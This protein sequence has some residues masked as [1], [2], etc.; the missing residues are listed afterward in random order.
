[1]DTVKYILGHPDFVQ[2]IGNIYPV[3]VKDYDKFNECSNVL[4]ITSQH[5]EFNVGD[6]YKLL[7][8]LV[9][10]ENG[11]FVSQLEQLFSLVTREKVVFVCSESNYGFVINEKYM[12]NRDNYEE[13]R[14]IVMKQNLLFEQ[15]VYKDKLVQEWA[16]RAM[17]AK[18]K[19]GIKITIQ[20]MITTISV[21]TGKNYE[22][23]SDMTI[24]QLQADF[25]RIN[26]F[27]DYQ[28]SVDFKCA[29][30]EKVNINHFAGF[31]NLF[32]SPYDN[33]FVSSNKLNNIE[34]AFK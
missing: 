31:I 1:M 30:A 3:K 25:K 5:F 8:L 28:T 27:Q 15:K 18:N 29:G 6:E 12:I 11:K 17:R 16:E 19:N 24:Y 20:D 22:E 10:L 32:E 34:K 21:F 9:V 23:I 4:Y 33:L 26:R 14:K 13:V 7:D 2:G